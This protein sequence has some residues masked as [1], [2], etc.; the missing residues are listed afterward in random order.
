[1]LKKTDDGVL[2][3]VKVIPKS[4]SNTVVGL[5]GDRLKVKVTAVPEKGKANQAVI[6]LLSKYLGIPKSS[7][8]IISGETAKQ[9]TVFLQGISID[10]KR[11]K[12][13]L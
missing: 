11:L 4:S 6:K 2:L 1:M 3:F 5:E 10:D 7:I 13:F 12:V 8:T 9:K